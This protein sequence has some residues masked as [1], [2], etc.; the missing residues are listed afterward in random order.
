MAEAFISKGALM[1]TGW[2]DNVKL[3]FVDGF[4][5]SLINNLCLSEVSFKEA[6][7]KT[8]SEKGVDPSYKAVFS[9]YPT[10]NENF[11]LAD[12]N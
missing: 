5:I 6:L 4:T 9:Y 11:S 3:D 12:I 7:Y 2:T 10:E 1:Y 8:A